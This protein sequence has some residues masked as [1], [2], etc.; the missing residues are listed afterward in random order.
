M[1]FGKNIGGQQ[2]NNADLIYFDY[3]ELKARIKDV[4]KELKSNELGDALTANTKFEETLAEQIRKVNDC[5]EL[6]Q[7]S[8]VARVS[9]LSEMVRQKGEGASPPLDAVPAFALE[10]ATASSSDSRASLAPVNELPDAFRQ[11]VQILAEVDRLRKY[12]VWNAVAVVKTLKKRRKQTNLGIEDIVAERTGWLSRQTFFSG[13]EF[14]ELHA[15]VES[16]GHQLMMSELAPAFSRQ[17]R[18]PTSQGDEPGELT[19]EQ[20]PICLERIS[21]MVEL[22]CGHRFC[23]KCFVLG[24]I[25]C[26]PGEYRISHCPICRRDTSPTTGSVEQNS[27]DFSDAAGG[28]ASDSLLW[29]FLHTYFPQSQG[30]RLP[31]QDAVDCGGSS[32]GTSVCAGDETMDMLGA[33]IKVVVGDNALQKLPAKEA[34]QGAPTSLTSE[35]PLPQ[36]T[37]GSSSACSWSA[38]PS[39]FFQTLPQRRPEEDMQQMRAAQK[40]QWLQVAS[41]G[42]PLAVDSSTYCSLCSEPLL[43]EAVVTTPCKHHFHRVC[44]SRLELPQCPL[45]DSDLPFSWF[46]PSEHPLSERGFRVVPMSKY[47]PQFPGGPSKGSMG[48]PLRL[49]PPVSLFLPDGTKMTSYLH[50]IPPMEDDSGDE[51]QG[52]VTPPSSTTSPASP[53]LLGGGAPSEAESSSGSSDENGE[54]SAPEDYFAYSALGRMRL[55]RLRDQGPGGSMRQKAANLPSMAPSG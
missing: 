18:H 7:R 23:W 4:V 32:Q 43:M 8:L 36:D 19:S 39:D 50:R 37:A 52:P 30:V 45:C 41:S 16:L 15:V 38:A 35:P 55:Y 49:P 3:N 21:D 54:G 22:N 53:V 9:S 12:A 6:H 40:L 1:R 24:P 47:R 27:S 14:T 25:A 42:D 51:F 34:D 46:V 2:L 28:R 29:R 17:G 44:V 13:S 33:L 20:C 5:F 48:Y 31:S 26:Q 11:L 10:A